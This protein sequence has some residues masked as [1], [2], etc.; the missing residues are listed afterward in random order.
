MCPSVSAPASP[1]AAESGIS[2]IPALSSTI[3]QI[4]LNFGDIDQFCHECAFEDE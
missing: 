4:L 3:K 2:P 1:H